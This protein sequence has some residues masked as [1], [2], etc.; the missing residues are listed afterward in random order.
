M[1]ASSAI[2][3]L[4]Y[5]RIDHMGRGTGAIFGLIEPNVED[6][7]PTSTHFGWVPEGTFIYASARD[8]DGNLFTCYRKLG[9][10]A[11]LGLMISGA[12]GASDR[13]SVRQ[14]AARPSFRGEFEQ[15]LDG[16][17]AHVADCPDSVRGPKSPMRPMR[18][19]RTPNMLTWDEGDILFLQGQ[20]VGNKGSAFMVP[21]AGINGGIYTSFMHYATGYVCG[22]EVTAMLGWAQN[23]FAPGVSWWTH[24]WRNGME[25]SWFDIGARYADGTLESG[26]LTTGSGGFGGCI[27]QRDGELLMVTN[28]VSATVTRNENLYPERIDYV[29]AGD[30]RASWSLAP[31][32]EVELPYIPG[33]SDMYRNAD[34]DFSFEGDDREQTAW[35]GWLDTY[36]DGRDGFIR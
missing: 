2:E 6:N 24:G 21:R 28:D 10:S 33:K 3:D 23:F 9:R 19:V 18:I 32:G 26:I 20:L 14:S 13:R 36:I 12:L 22:R 31:H 29:I 25:H 7:L 16:N 5:G 30:R 15:G 27:L 17:G 34:G 11:T 4:A 8:V 35:T 1:P